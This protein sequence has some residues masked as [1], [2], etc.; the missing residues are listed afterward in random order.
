MNEKKLPP[1][2]FG[3]RT[4]YEKWLESEGISVVTGYHLDDV[5]KVPLQPWPR[6]GGLGAFINLE[7]TGGA[8]NDAYVCEIPPG[9]SLLPQR[10]LYE[11]C[12][13]ILSGYGATTVWTEGGIKQT[14]EWQEG[15]MF[16]PPLN[17]WH[18]HFNGQSNNPVRY[19]AV[20]RAPVFMNLFHDLDF[21]MQN[22]YI[23]K[24]KYRWEEGYFSAQ[25]KA[26]QPEVYDDPSV[27]DTN[28]VPDCRNFPL[29][30]EGEGGMGAIS[31]A[32]FEMSN[33][34]LTA[35]ISQQPSG[36]YKKAH[37]HGAGAHLICLGGEGYTL[38]WPIESGIMAE[39]VERVRVD[40]RKNSLFSPP[41]KWFHQHFS[42]GKE[43]LTLLA[44][45]P[46]RSNKYAGIKKDSR[47]KKRGSFKQGG[48]QI[49]FEDEDPEIRR[50]FR[51]ELAKNGVPW[52][53]S[54]YFPGE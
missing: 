9:G 41:E 35:H 28:F 48:T 44:F 21:I 24:N 42:T 54:P 4:S 34:V 8:E 6:K 46:D 53:M 7:G 2:P 5:M 26:F 30:E 23:F 20:T 40:Y 19:V 18:Q 3:T 45:H 39:G 37:H 15:S 13:Y 33:N 22:D 52:H 27:W 43:P 31:I 12:I 47:G 16:A 51:E 14:F 17:T 38:M 49:E 11:E 36:T 1:S 32:Y 50:L 25:G 10:H 29:V